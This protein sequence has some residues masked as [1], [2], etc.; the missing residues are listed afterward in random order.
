V[1]RKAKKRIAAAQ[2]SLAP[3]KPAKAAKAAKRPARKRAAA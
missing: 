1:A 2:R 3:A